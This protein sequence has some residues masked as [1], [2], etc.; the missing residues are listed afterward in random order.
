MAKITNSCRCL[1]EQRCYLWINLCGYVC[2]LLPILLGEFRIEVNWVLSSALLNTLLPICNIYSGVRPRTLPHTIHHTAGSP[3]AQ[4]TVIAVLCKNV[5]GFSTTVVST[6]LTFMP[7]IY[8]SCLSACLGCL[9]WLPACLDI[10][11][12]SCQS[13]LLGICPLLGMIIC[14]STGMPTGRSA[15]M[16]AGLLTGF[17][18]LPVCPRAYLSA[19]LHAYLPVR[20]PSFTNSCFLLLKILV[21]WKIVKCQHDLVVFTPFC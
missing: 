2:V 4:H 15:C 1:C 5:V 7:V 9:S 19:S 11:L 16:P 6:L 3:A 17:S 13:N 8:C 21:H 18:C 12:S 10:C 20:L 14:L